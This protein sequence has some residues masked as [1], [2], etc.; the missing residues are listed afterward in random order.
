MDTGFFGMVMMK[1][2]SFWAEGDRVSHSQSG[3]IGHE[4]EGSLN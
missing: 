4:L 1:V 3:I 2:S